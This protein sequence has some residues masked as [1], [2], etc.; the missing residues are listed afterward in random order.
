MSGVPNYLNH[1]FFLDPVVGTIFAY[2]NSANG[3]FFNATTG[4]FVYPFTANG[5]LFFPWGYPVQNTFTTMDLGILKGPHTI[6]YVPSAVDNSIYTTIKIVYDFG[7]GTT[8]TVEKDIIVDYRTVNIASYT[9][10][11]DPGNPIYTNVSHDYYPMN[12]SI[13]TYTTMISV[14]DGNSVFHIFQI[15]L[16]SVPLSFYDIDDVNLLNKVGLSNNVYDNMVVMQAGTDKYV[17]NFKLLTALIPPT[18]S[19]TP[20]MTPTVT[21]TMTVTPTVTPSITPTNTITPTR[22]PT[23]TITPTVTP[24]NTVT[25]TRT[26]TPTVTPTVTPTRTPTLTP[27][28]TPTLTPNIPAG[29]PP[30]VCVSDAGTVSANGTYSLTD[31]YF[32]NVSTGGLPVI[33]FDNLASPVWDL[34]G[35]ES[36]YTNS[37]VTPNTFPTAGWA[38]AGGQLSIPSFAT[39]ACTPSPTPTPSITPTITPTATPTV[40]PSITPSV[41]PTIGLSPTPTPSITPTITVTPTVSQTPTVTPTR[42]PTPTVTPSITPSVTPTVTLTPSI[43]P[44][45]TP[46]VTPSAGTGA[47]VGIGG[48]TLVT[49]AGDN[50]IQI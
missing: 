45:V 50:I 1:Y 23:P 20:T 9:I 12:S 11:S 16:S 8:Q 18:P 22:T 46:T 35:S 3:R 27:T 33:Y 31:K 30:F 13:T 2:P 21:P 29:F 4:T 36:L 10:G 43:T 34:S 24:T 41:T 25:P 48:D 40:T 42:T 6:T 39:V 32:Y 26:P 5:A 44:T 38:Q 14:V 49:I 7:E 17:T 19:P 15:N 47:I 28:P 37:S